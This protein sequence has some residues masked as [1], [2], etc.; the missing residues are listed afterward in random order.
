MLN[1]RELSFSAQSLLLLWKIFWNV[2]FFPHFV[3]SPPSP[4][5]QIRICFDTLMKIW[6][7]FFFPGIYHRSKVDFGTCNSLTPTVAV[8]VKNSCAIHR[9]FLCRCVNFVPDKQACAK[10][11]IDLFSYI[12]V[13]CL[14]SPLWGFQ[15]FI[16]KWLLIKISC[17]VYSFNLTQMQK[18]HVLN[19]ISWLLF[20]SKIL[21]VLLKICGFRKNSADFKFTA[22]INLS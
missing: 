17:F 1:G 7:N 15:F 19:N 6:W 8:C 21:R 22:R 5:F 14:T 11:R 10:E 3:S 18:C 4:L 12:L 2:C 9:T 13:V 20:S 16:I